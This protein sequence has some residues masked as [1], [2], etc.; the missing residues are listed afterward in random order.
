MISFN[1]KDQQK[2]Y[3]DFG[4]A[5]GID[6]HQTFDQPSDL[7]AQS[8]NHQIKLKKAFISKNEEIRYLGGVDSAATPEV[9]L[10]SQQLFS[11]VFQAPS[12][13]DN[14]KSN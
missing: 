2:R 4:K 3:S 7:A 9:G 14:I 10:R 6:H 5:A 11:T 1:S 12:T 8:R 13:L